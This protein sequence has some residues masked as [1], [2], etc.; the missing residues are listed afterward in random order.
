MD[1]H[2]RRCSDELFAADID[3]KF[4][5]AR[6]G[7]ADGFEQR[8]RRTGKSGTKSLA[9]HHLEVIA[10]FRS[11][12]DLRHFC[13]VLARLVVARF[14]RTHPRTKRDGLAD[15]WQSGGI[16]C[17]ELEI[18]PV[19]MSLFLAMVHGDDLIR[20]EQM[21]IRT[22]FGTRMAK[23]YRLDLKNKIIAQRAGEDQ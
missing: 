17:S 11:R 5:R 23:G 14:L 10:A 7:A 19:P 4:I 1:E 8:A 9:Q 12:D 3:E 15:T 21:H 6:I 18:I 16:V 22:V 2:L 20:K 13:S